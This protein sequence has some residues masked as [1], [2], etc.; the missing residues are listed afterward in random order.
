MKLFNMNMRKMVAK[1]GL[2]LLTKRQDWI[3][4]MT[5]Q[6]IQLYLVLDTHRDIEHA[7]GDNIFW[8]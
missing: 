1:I 6:Y 4:H 2:L 3:S 5:E 7:T 8:M